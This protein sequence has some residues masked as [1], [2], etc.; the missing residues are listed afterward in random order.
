MLQQGKARQH[1]EA[2]DDSAIQSAWHRDFDLISGVV[3]RVILVGKHGAVVFQNDHFKKWPEAL[4]RNTK[5]L[6]EFTE[7]LLLFRLRRAVH[8]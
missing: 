2:G 4:F 6:Q 1:N 5:G 7:Q 3:F 8:Q